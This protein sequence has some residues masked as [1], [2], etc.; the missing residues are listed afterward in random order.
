MGTVAAALVVKYLPR[1]RRPQ[2]TPGIRAVVFTKDSVLIPIWAVATQPHYRLG[3]E[4]LEDRGRGQGLAAM[5]S[6]SLRTF[7]GMMYEAVQ[8]N[9]VSLPEQRFVFLHCS[10]WL[11]HFDLERS[12]PS[13]SYLH[14]HH[15][16]KN[17]RSCT[18]SSADLMIISYD[19]C[20]APVTM[21]WCC[22]S[23]FAPLR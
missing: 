14:H 2:G 4:K 9:L 7:I 20:G 21:W 12:T 15:Q 18:E 17:S 23:T 3:P 19:C 10:S 22:T 16:T 5:L 1:T 11:L 8:T 13:A 6:L